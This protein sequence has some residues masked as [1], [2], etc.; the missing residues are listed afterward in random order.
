MLTAN[1]LGR[2]TWEADRLK[3]LTG[4]NMS[5]TIYRLIGISIVWTCG[6]AVAQGQVLQL[7]TL[8]YFS[9]R[10]S[11]MVPDSGGAFLGGIG[12]WAERSRTYGLGRG[13][14]LSNR[15]IESSGGASLAS[16]HA[17]IIDHEAMD[18]AVRAAARGAVPSA[19]ELRAA[20][21]SERMRTGDSSGEGKTGL[22]SVAEARRR[23]AE[24]KASLHAEAAA[25]FSDGQAAEARGEIGTARI[26]YQMA[27]KRADGDLQQT[28]RARLAALPDGKKKPPKPVAHTVK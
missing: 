24:R 1:R 23:S 2:Y 15:M 19:E 7:P 9:V 25:M 11:V 12:R 13:P 14:L 27:H 17:T 20:A 4:L 28:I 8:D 26:F 10:T 21:A 5:S 18:R 3:G 16:V 22:V 6:A